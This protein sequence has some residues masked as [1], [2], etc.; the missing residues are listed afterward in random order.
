MRSVRVLAILLAPILFLVAAPSCGDSSPGVPDSPDGVVKAVSEGLAANQPEVLWKALPASYQQ[1]VNELVRLFASTMDAELYDR[2]VSV[3]GKAIRVLRGKKDFLLN[4]VMVRMI[5][6]PDKDEALRELAAATELLETVVASELSSLSTLRTLDVGAF[7]RG[8]GRTLMR[9]FE[10]VS[11]FLEGDAFSAALKDKIRG[12]RA[13]VVSMQGDRSVLRIRTPGQEPAVVPLVMEVPF[14]RVE[15]RWLPDEFVRDWKT[16]VGDAR[17][18]I[19]ALTAR[20][21][22]A[23]KAKYLATLAE[24]ESV[25]DRLAAAADQKEF[26]LLVSELLGRFLGGE[27]TGPEQRRP[28]PPAPDPLR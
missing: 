16:I 21:A 14:V 20:T 13:E 7:L 25:L 26:N 11:A 10:T 3:A 12:V 8:T 1:D 15:G 23:E 19:E 6:A 24:L 4:H 27:A 18:Q 2:G 5:A 22:G 9:Q 17:Q 28:A